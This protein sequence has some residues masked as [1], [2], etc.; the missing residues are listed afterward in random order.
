MVTVAHRLSEDLATEAMKSIEG[1]G[2][3]ILLPTDVDELHSM[4]NVAF[5]HADRLKFHRRMSAALLD[6]QLPKYDYFKESKA[7]PT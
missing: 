2:R 4:M 7:T 5:Y 6:E 1:G 3:N